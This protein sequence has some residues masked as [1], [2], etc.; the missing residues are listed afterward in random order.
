MDP[1]AI[2]QSYLQRNNR[3]VKMYSTSNPIKQPVEPI[4]SEDLLSSGEEEEAVM[5]RSQPASRPSRPAPS[6][7][8]GGGSSGY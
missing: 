3:Y 2:V 7:P 8:S 1:R 4:L 6:T 5:P